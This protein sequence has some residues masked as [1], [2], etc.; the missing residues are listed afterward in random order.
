M[1]ED[2]KWYVL[3]DRETS[4]W[5]ARLT[6]AGV[7]ARQRE[8]YTVREI[9]PEVVLPPVDLYS[10]LQEALAYYRPLPGVPASHVDRLRRAAAAALVLAESKDGWIANPVAYIRTACR[11]EGAV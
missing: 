4:L 9:G 10:E 3:S 7:R 2:A 11:N 6:V 1:S 5:M 8:G